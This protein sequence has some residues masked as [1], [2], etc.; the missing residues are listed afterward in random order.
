[1]NEHH[2]HSFFNLVPIAFFTKWKP[3]VCCRHRR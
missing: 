2:R 3:T 1:L